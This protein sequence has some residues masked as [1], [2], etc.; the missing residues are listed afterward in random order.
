MTD[1]LPRVSP[2]ANLQVDHTGKT[3]SKGRSREASSLHTM[4]KWWRIWPPT[5]MINWD[6][7]PFCPLK[8][9]M[10]EKNLWSWSLDMS[11]PSPL[12]FY[13][14]FLL[15][16]WLPSSEQSNLSLVTGWYLWV[17]I[18]GCPI[19]CNESV[20][21]GY[22]HVIWLPSVMITFIC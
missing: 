15:D 12:P 7:F 13:W 11:P 17:D 5:L 22:S 2:L 16:Y 18:P 4:E 8:I 20:A 21:K 14:H 10:A 9:V 6:S 19:V 1:S 3:A